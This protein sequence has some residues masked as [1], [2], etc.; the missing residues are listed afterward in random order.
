MPVDTRTSSR[1]DP[2]EPST[3]CRCSLE[4]GA[5]ANLR[6][7]THHRLTPSG[8]SWHHLRVRMRMPAKT[9]CKR[10]W[11]S[12]AGRRGIEWKPNAPNERGEAGVRVKR[13]QE[14]I[15]L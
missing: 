9:R 11:K 7:L 2:Y 10:L 6:R 1:S 4:K 14:G 12:R 5:A 15:P 13:A 3:D 8:C